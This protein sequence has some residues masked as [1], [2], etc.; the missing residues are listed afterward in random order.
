MH[1]RVVNSYEAASEKVPVSLVSSVDLP[2]LGNPTSPTRVSPDWGHVGEG[3][4]GRG[5]TTH[6]SGAYERVSVCDGHTHRGVVA[7]YLGHIETGRCF[8]TTSALHAPTQHT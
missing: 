2:T 5:H 6:A 3:G 8:T 1:V 7:T 4:G